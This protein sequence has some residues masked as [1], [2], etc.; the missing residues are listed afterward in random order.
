MGLCHASGDKT[1]GQTAIQERVKRSFLFTS[2]AADAS[3]I[4]HTSKTS[5]ASTTLHFI[6]SLKAQKVDPFQPGFLQ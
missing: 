5:L 4:F 6:V 3:D 1:K 2:N